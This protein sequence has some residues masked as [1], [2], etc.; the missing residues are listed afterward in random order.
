[1]HDLLEQWARLTEWLQSHA[2]VTVE[3]LNPP[4]KPSRV[5]EA[6]KATGER[7][8]PELH[9]WF[10]LHNGSDQGH[11]FPQIVPGFR[12][13]SLAE[14]EVDWRSMVSIWADTTEEFEQMED[15]RPK[16]QP[17]GTTAFTYLPSFIPIAADDT[18]ER[19]IVDTR[20][21]PDTGCVVAF[22][23]DGTDEGTSRWP[24]IASMLQETTDSLES[25]APCRGWVPYIEAGQLYWDYS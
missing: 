7:W 6:E 11:A 20:P 13:V 5:H 24:S 3:G 12:P 22:S 23:G 15:M 4:E 9:A 10:G 17:A 1:M 8:T 2:P 21:G 25:G 16:S 18:R 14:L 19:L